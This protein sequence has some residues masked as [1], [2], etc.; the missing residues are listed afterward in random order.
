MS[1]GA[2]IAQ[3]RV[4]YPTRQL[5]RY[6]TNV[7]DPTPQAPDGVLIAAVLAGD[8]EQFAGLV[9]RY[10]RPLLRVARSRMGRPDWAEDVVQDTFLSA[11][12]S[13]HSYDSRYSFRTWMWTILLNQCR[14][15][16]KRLAKDIRETGIP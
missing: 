6:H 8:R 4:Q 9:S 5:S 7:T 1:S 11:F 14:R 12:K 10:Q 15:H 13:L 2:T 3:I 16:L